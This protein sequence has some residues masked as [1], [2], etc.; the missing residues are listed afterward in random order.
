MRRNKTRFQQLRTCQLFQQNPTYIT[1]T[2]PFL[3]HGV[4]T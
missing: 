3:V 1:K 4:K 2:K